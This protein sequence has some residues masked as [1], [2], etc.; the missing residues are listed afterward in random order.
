MLIVE[1]FFMEIAF[2]SDIH[3]NIESLNA[4]VKE[5]KSIGIK[6]FVAL[7]DYVGYYYNP[8][9]VLDCLLS[10]E[11]IMI[12]GNHEEMLL[13]AIKDKK[14]LNELTQ[15]YGHSY[16]F[17]IDD[18]SSEYLKILGN[19]PEKK[20][21][22]LTDNFEILICHGSPNSVDEYIYPDASPNDVKNLINGYDC[23]AYGHTHYQKIF[24]FGKQKI[25]FNPGSVG[26]PRE[27][28]KKG[29]CWCTLNTETKKVSLFDTPYDKTNV[30]TAAKKFDENIPYL[31]KVLERC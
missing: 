28:G 29:A 30:I 18:L 13:K 6:K 2:F 26:Q 8:S 22:N 11:A 17:A 19:L 3:G 31:Y 10:I 5:A 24:N 9:Q 23:V 4:V 20:I 12:R 15:K 14:F 25:M 27:R 7:G 1:S 21:L 16:Q